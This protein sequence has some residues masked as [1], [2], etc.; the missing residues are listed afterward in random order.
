MSEEITI[1]KETKETKEVKVIKGRPRPVTQKRDGAKKLDLKNSAQLFNEEF[2]IY[3][4]DPTVDVTEY[5]ADDGNIDVNEIPAENLIEFT[6]RYIDPG[7][8]QEIL[9]TPLAYDLP[10]AKNLTQEAIEEVI[11]KAIKDRLSK[12]KTEADIRYE[13]LLACIIDPKFESVEQIKRILPAALQMEL[14]DEMI[15]GAIGV[16]LV[17]RFQESN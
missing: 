10:T 3:W 15:K 5:E 8:F 1:T 13:V 17:A 14:Y 16:N 6:C 4:P 7:T 11:R 9:N 2:Y 12:T